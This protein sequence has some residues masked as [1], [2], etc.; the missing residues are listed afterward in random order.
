MWQR[1][2]CG[3]SQRRPFGQPHGCSHL[4]WAWTGMCDIW[5]QHRSSR[6]EELALQKCIT[7]GASEDGRA[8]ISLLPW[9]LRVMSQKPASASSRGAA[10]EAREPPGTW[11]LRSLV[12]NPSRDHLPLKH[13]GPI[14]PPTL[15]SKGGLYPVFLDSS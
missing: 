9:G 3:K 13:Q 7:Q 4:G 5:L 6:A 12:Y 1:E 14:M 2:K 11:K 8:L 10:G 15:A